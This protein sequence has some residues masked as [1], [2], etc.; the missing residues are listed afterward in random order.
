MTGLDILQNPIQ[1]ISTY[2]TVLHER[3]TCLSCVHLA[4]T[5]LLETL[6]SAYAAGRAGYSKYV[7]RAEE[8]SVPS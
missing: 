5:T 6:G 1:P 4:T 7:E 3:Q 2:G 8:A